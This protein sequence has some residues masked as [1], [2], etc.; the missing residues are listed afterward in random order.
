MGFEASGAPQTPEIND[1][2]PAQNSCKPIWSESLVQTTRTEDFR[3]E[4]D[5]A[6]IFNA[7]RRIA[8]TEPRDSGLTH[9]PLKPQG[10]VIVISTPCD[11]D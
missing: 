9:R 6:L 8:L 11:R 4:G 3:P 1:F 7:V 2:R 10:R 5:R